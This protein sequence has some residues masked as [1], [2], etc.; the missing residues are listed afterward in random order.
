MKM[1]IEKYLA[2]KKPL[3]DREIEKVLPREISQKWLEH[4]LG[5]AAFAYDA[6]TIGKSMAEPIWEYLDRGGKRWRPGLTLLC[7]E[8]VGGKEKEA[9]AFTPLIELVHNGTIM[10]DDLEDDSK[11][12]RGKPCAHLLYGVDVAVNDGNAMYFIPLTLLYRNT[13]KLGQ[14][15]LN[16][17]YNLYAEEMLRVSIGQAMDIWWHK[18]KKA[19]IKEEHYLQMVVYKTGVLARF[20]ARLGTILGNGSQKQIEALGKFGEALGIGF[21]IQDDILELTGDEFKKGKGSAGGDI[22]EGKR[23]LL[24]IKTLEKASPEDRKCLLEIL[25]SH[26]TDAETINQAIEII[27][28]YGAIEYAAK[29]ANA[30]VESAWEKIDSVLPKSKAKE[31]LHNMALYCTKREI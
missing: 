27:K 14:E 2:E 12:R 16:K 28:K 25:D 26:P 30:I 6:E 10:V 3:I 1:D 24:V 8:A 13:Q 9:L 29:K 19:D 20:A 18:G 17:I 22:H 15:K 4:S 23:T 7:C 31:L 11:E 5:K 21:Q